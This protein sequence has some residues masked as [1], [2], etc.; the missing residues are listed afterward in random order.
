MKRQ[1]LLAT[2]SLDWAFTL[3]H[4]FWWNDIVWKKKQGAPSWS[5]DPNA[6][7]LYTFHSEVIAYHDIS[8]GVPVALA[9]NFHHQASWNPEASVAD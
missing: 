4:A 3:G 8:A 1:Q 2:V 9:E 6:I 7:F 5:K